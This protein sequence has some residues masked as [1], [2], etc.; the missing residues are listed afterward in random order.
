[1]E[2]TLESADAEA[3]VSRITQTV[4]IVV[5]IENCRTES[6]WAE[7][8]RAKR[9]GPTATKQKRVGVLFFLLTSFS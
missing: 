4:Y 6:D 7:A 1:M 9:R 2:L 3:A 8:A 5:R